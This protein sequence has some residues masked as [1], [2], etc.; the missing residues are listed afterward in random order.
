MATCEWKM[1]HNDI[2]QSYSISYGVF[3]DFES[4]LDL[5]MRF[6]NYQEMLAISS[7]LTHRSLIEKAGY[8]DENLTINQDGEFF[9]R[10]LVHVDKVVYDSEGKIFYR[11]PSEFNVS[12]QKSEKAMKSLLE[13]Y[14]CYEKVVLKFEDS[15][16]SMP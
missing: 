10:V 1:F 12:Q 4:G 13:S 2:Q 3:H 11:T 9:A 6:W 15:F 7:Y 14:N 5:L 16:T 8:W